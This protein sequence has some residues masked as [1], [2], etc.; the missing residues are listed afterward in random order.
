MLSRSWCIRHA[1][2]G[3]RSE[4]STFCKKLVLSQRAV[5]LCETEATPKQE[6]FLHRVLAGEVESRERSR[7]SRLLTRA[8]FPAFKRLDGYDRH[9][10]KLPSAL[11]W[12]DLTEGTFI[13]SKRNLVL[14]GPVGTVKTHWL[15]TAGLRA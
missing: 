10:V 4:N 3:G 7:R 1:S 9:G 11:Q 5:Q 12:N 14:Y 6:E 2:T 15:I 13:Q 8:G